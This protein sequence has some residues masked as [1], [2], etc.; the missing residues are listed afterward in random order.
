MPKK[1]TAFAETLKRLRIRANLSQLTLSRLT[2]RLADEGL[3]Q[4]GL[5]QQ[6]ISVLEKGRVPHQPTIRTL[7]IALAHGLTE[8][9]YEDVTATEVEQ[10]LTNAT[11]ELRVER[12]YVSPDAAKADALMVGYPKWFR[13]VLWSIVHAIIPII[14]EG[15]KTGIGSRNNNASQSD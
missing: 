1:N 8:Q 3:V 14:G 6:H 15:V 4:G 9:G 11:F 13:A 10:V 12:K 5:M 2:Y 7:S